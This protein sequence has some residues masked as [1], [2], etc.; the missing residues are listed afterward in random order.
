M[1]SGTED[2]PPAKRIKVQ[3]KLTSFFS[4]EAFRHSESEDKQS[5]E[6]AFMTYL[7][8]ESIQE[9]KY[10][11]QSTTGDNAGFEGVSL[12]AFSSRKGYVSFD[13]KQFIQALI[14][15]INARMIN[16]NNEAVIKQLEAL[17]LDKWNI[18][19]ILKRH[20]RLLTRN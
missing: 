9:E 16:P 8:S 18:P 1:E 7:D 10:T 4:S 19:T 17:I 14:N 15:N 3:K 20:P 6:P 5:N 2:Q 13:Q 11:F 12:E